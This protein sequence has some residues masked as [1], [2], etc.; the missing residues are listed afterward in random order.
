MRNI[1]RP[2]L[3][4][5]LFYSH[6][7][8]AAEIKNLRDQRYCEI[9]TIKQISL[10]VTLNV[11]NTILL[12]DCPSSLWSTISEESIK[13]EK[14]LSFA[15]LNGPRYWTIDQIRN[16]KL[17]DPTIES[18]SGLEMRLAGILELN[19]WDILG[20]AQP[21]TIKTVNR[22]V[23]WLFE[24]NKARFQLID[25]QGRRYIMQSYSIQKDETL[26][27]TSL[28]KLKEK[29]HLPKGWDFVVDQ[30]DEDLLLESV[31]GRAQV[32]QDDLGNTYTMVP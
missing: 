10:K 25:E 6:L 20:G 23:T 29:L 4:L 24:A 32:L 1:L 18:F 5:V 30:A 21:Y 15:H 14:N 3:F 2:I 7:G 11:Y 27:Y 16:T 9:L 31:N 13:K 19:Y 17:Q 28:A 22:N 26:T 12:N 8:M